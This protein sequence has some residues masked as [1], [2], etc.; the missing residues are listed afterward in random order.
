ML[1]PDVVLGGSLALLS[2]LT[3]GSCMVLI[4]VGMRNMRSEPGSLLAAAAGVPIGVLISSFQL[5]WGG[6]VPGFNALTVTAFALA[7]IFSTYLGRWLVFKSIE[8]IGPSGASALQSTSPL[9]TALFAWVFL[10]EAIGWMGVFGITLAILGLM[11]MSL[12]LQKR[13]SDQGSAAGK[14]RAGQAM[15]WGS[16]A[17]GIASS[18]A[19]SGSHIFRGSA[20]RVWNEPL[21]GAT[22]GAAAGFLV[23][24]LA[25]RTKLEGY[26]LEILANPRGAAL[27]AGI[28]AL[29]FFAQSLVIASMKYIPVSVAA[30]IYM[31]TPL[32]VM[33]LSYFVLRNHEKLNWVMVL[34]I[35]ITLCGAA[36]SLLIAGLR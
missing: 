32:V 13:A 28:G 33:P 30:L 9:L 4:S 10:G 26:R 12:G 25:S 22:I 29:Q 17:F 6:V 3:Y 7:G 8:R 36:I 5:A 2:M 16:L 21:L 14:G 35:L 15:V 18:V 34:G 1:L 27:F 23:L 24:L 11:A 19:Y 31:C 20:V